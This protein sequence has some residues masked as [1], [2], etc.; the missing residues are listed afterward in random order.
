MPGHGA[1][2]PGDRTLIVKKAARWTV[3]VEGRKM[4][5]YPSAVG[6]RL[7]PHEAADLTLHMAGIG[8]VHF[9]AVSLQN[10]G[11]HHGGCIQRRLGGAIGIGKLVLASEFAGIAQ[12][13]DE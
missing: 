4:D 13:S 8:G 11:L 6:R 2:L 5:D 1:P 7:R 12:P 9:D 3:V 10:S